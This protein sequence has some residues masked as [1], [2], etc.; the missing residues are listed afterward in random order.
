MKPKRLNHTL[1][2]INERKEHPDKKWTKKA[3]IKRMASLSENERRENEDYA[4]PSWIYIDTNIYAA[5]RRIKNGYNLLSTLW[6]RNV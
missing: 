2:I 6:K 5:I 4:L 3:I 1:Y